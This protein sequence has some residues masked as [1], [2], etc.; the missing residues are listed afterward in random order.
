MKHLIDIMEL[1]VEEIQELIAL[2]EDIMN[3]PEKY[4][5]KFAEAGWMDTP[6]IVCTKTMPRSDAKS[7]GKAV[8]SRKNPWKRC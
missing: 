5:E 6:E 4:R 1:S 8:K 7:R 3:F 2:A